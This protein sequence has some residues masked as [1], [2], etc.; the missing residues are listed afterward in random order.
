LATGR[1]LV[2]IHKYEE[3]FDNSENSFDD[4]STEIRFVSSQHRIKWVRHT[5]MI[6]RVSLPGSFPAESNITKI[7][8]LRS[9]QFKNNK[10]IIEDF[11]PLIKD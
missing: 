6:G 5:E 9:V 10:E 1:H 2:E 11:F 4:F 3:P 7:A 8:A